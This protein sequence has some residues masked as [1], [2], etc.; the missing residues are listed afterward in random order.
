MSK[1][2]KEA[3]DKIV[4]SEELRE[5]I[6]NMSSKKSKSK[7]IGTLYFRMAACAACLVICVAAVKISE[8]NPAVV[9]PVQT[10]APIAPAV[11]YIPEKTPATNTSKPEKTPKSE[12]MPK[13]NQ[14]IA[15]G[16]EDNKTETEKPN[17][18]IKL[19]ENDEKITET[20]PPDF[21]GGEVMSPFDEESA[22]LSEIRNSVGYDFKIPGY[23][24]DGYKKESAN[25]L[26]GELIQIIYLDNKNKI[27]YRTQKTDEDISGDYNIYDDVH[28]ELINNNAVTFKGTEDKCSNAVW[29]ED[30]S[31]YSLYFDCGMSYEEV[32]KI[33]KS[34]ILTNNA[35]AK[36]IKKNEKNNQN[37]L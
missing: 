33:I 3:M 8:N 29:T 18:N 10:A 27:M 24:P 12:D 13:N 7:R 17:I 16:N 36:E 1:K 28:T 6:I 5:K 26:F 25:L 19:P 11:T 22:E 37:T 2:Y 31:S 4:V 32:S 21:G 9:P 35:E 15:R 14:N 34:M 20:L 30:E 23:I